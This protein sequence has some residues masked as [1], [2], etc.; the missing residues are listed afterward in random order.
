MAALY[1]VYE[2]EGVTVDVRPARSTIF[3]FF[4]DLACIIGGIYALAMF[5]DRIMY[6]ICGKPA[7]YELVQ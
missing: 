6:S 2:I 1:F 5:L 4:F 7:G 3:Y